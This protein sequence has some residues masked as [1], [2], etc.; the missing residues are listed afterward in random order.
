[1]ETSSSSKRPATPS[2]AST[3][4][5]VA[6]ARRLRANL[7][8]VASGSSS[9]PVNHSN[10]GFCLNF[11]TTPSPPSS[12]SAPSRNHPNPLPYRRQSDPPPPYST[13]PSHRESRTGASRG[14]AE[15]TG[16]E[17]ERR[18]GAKKPGVKDEQKPKW[19]KLSGS[20][21]T[22]KDVIAREERVLSRDRRMS[23]DLASLGL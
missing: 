23:D 11:R 10:L 7:P 2:E 9:T 20:G 1:M 6:R 12:E 22:R 17:L 4:K 8:P 16:I 15:E 3:F 13:E 19:W 18:N 14:Q 21:R 5:S